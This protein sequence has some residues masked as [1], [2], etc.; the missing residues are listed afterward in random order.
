MMEAIVSIAL[1][2]SVMVIVFPFFGQLLENDHQLEI[3]KGLQLQQE[4]ESEE[5]IEA[6]TTGTEEFFGEG[7][8]LRITTE[9]HKEY[10]SLYHITKEW[11]N[12]KNKV[13]Y[14]LTEYQYQP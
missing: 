13:I 4:I 10:P 11:V 9:R 2:S 6:L 14:S 8:T 1:I 5:Q 7:I 3:M 12:A